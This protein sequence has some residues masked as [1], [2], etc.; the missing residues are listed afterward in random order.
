MYDKKINEIAN[1]LTIFIDENNLGK[2]ELLLGTGT[3][4]GETKIFI[5]YKNVDNGIEYQMNCLGQERTRVI[6]NRFMYNLV[7]KLAN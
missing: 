4:N 1:A 2:Y 5:N 7:K 6:V 3:L